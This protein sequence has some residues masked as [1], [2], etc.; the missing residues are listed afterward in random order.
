VSFGARN[1]YLKSQWKAGLLA[2]AVLFLAVNVDA[3]TKV[4]KDPVS[5]ELKTYLVSASADEKPTAKL[6]TKVKPNDVI[7]YRA[8]Y[9][10]N[11]AGKIKNLAATLPIPVETNSWV[12]HNQK[13]HKQV[14]MV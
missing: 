6:V 1:M 14:Q 3:A 9:T 12:S 7:E 8:T 11:T 4:S 5:V 2:V 10:N 13:V